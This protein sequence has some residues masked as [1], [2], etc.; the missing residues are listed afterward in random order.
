MMTLNVHLHDENFLQANLKATFK[1]KEDD[2]S[3][4]TGAKVVNDMS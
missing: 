2:G 3:V 4:L 1:A